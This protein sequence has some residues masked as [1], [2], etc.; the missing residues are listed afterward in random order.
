MVRR[1]SCWLVVSSFVIVE[2]EPQRMR[3]DRVDI[4]IDLGATQEDHG[5]VLD[6]RDQWRVWS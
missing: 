5:E 2:L 6:I 4:F 1:I 3:D